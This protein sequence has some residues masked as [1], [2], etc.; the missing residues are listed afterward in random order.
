MPE[1]AAIVTG[2]SRGIG[3][4]IADALGADGYKLTLT[5]R[6]PE[7][8]DA[9][10]AEL[11]EKGYEVQHLAANLNDEDWI[12]AVVQAHPEKVRKLVDETREEMLKQMQD[13]LSEEEFKA[14]KEA[15]ER[16]PGFGGEVWCWRLVGRT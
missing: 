9:A 6:K 13:V 1:R 4:A 5:A 2:A 11:K 7:T 15:V 16:R 8:L 12:K 3:F 14:F 10:A